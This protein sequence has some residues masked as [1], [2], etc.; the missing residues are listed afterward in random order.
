MATELTEKAKLDF[1]AIKTH[2][3]PPVSDSTPPSARQQWINDCCVAVAADGTVA[4]ISKDN[5][6]VLATKGNGRSWQVSPVDTQNAG[7]SSYST[8]LVN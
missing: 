8:Y 6:L 3:Y 7:Y 1:E 4:S 5:T 2:L